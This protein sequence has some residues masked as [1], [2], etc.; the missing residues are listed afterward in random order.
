[1]AAQLT[2]RIPQADLARLDKMARMG[3]YRS[4]NEL[5]GSILHAVSAH[6]RPVARQSEP[7]AA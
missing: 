7:K 1:M 3:G 2:V 4:R 6:N 5:A